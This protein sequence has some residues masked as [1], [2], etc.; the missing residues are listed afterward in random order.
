MRA[1][2]AFTLLLAAGCG[3][4]E[5]HPNLDR[6]T[7][8][9]QVGEWLKV[10]ARQTLDRQNWY[11]YGV[12]LAG[13]V[14][15]GGDVAVAAP[16]AANDMAGAS[17]PGG[18]GSAQDWST[19][20]VQEE[21]VDEAD[22]VKNDG[23]HIFVL[24]NDGLSILDAWPAEQLHEAAFFDVEGTPTNLYFDGA[25]TV[26]I[27]SQLGQ[28]SPNPESG[29]DPLE[30]TASAAGGWSYDPISKLSVLDVA[31]RTAPQLV[32]E[33]YI[34]G[35]ISASR[36]IGSSLHVITTNDLTDF[37]WSDADS[38]FGA[39]TRRRARVDQSEASDWIPTMQDNV[40]RDG[41]WESTTGPA[42]TCEATFRPNVR[43]E[44]AWSSI[45]TLDLADP[46]AAVTSTG[47]LAR[48]DVAYASTGALYL[49]MSEWEQG[50]FASQD[51][52]VQSRI[53]RFELSSTGAEYD[54]SGVVDGSLL[55]SYSLGEFGGHLRVAT[56]EWDDAGASNAVSVLRPQS[57]VLVEVGKVDG[58][59][60]GESIYAVRF[61][62]D[63]GY[64]VTFQQID[65]LFTLDLSDPADP[66]VV[67]ELEVTGFSTYL[68]P[69]DED[70]LLAVGE[71]ISADG[72]SWMGFQVSL[73]DVTD[74]T[75]P[76]LM[77][78]VIAGEGYGSSEAQ[79]DPHAF[80]WY[81]PR[82]TLG[83]PL[84][85]YDYDYGVQETS[86]ELYHVDTTTGIEHTG[87]VDHT[88]FVDEDTRSWGW[89]DQVRRSIFIEDYVFAVSNLGVQ[90]AMIDDP[91]TTLA[92]FPLGSPSCGWGGGMAEVF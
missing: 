71:E 89:C 72:W 12:P 28:V 57:G 52:S 5:A 65:P 58:I 23:D 30:T 11:G 8:C 3:A 60:R 27:F 76:E 92:S 83:L 75:E 50:P 53:H 84:V 35:R 15:R 63:R 6:F 46:T 10:S 85:D 87:S 16:E 69:I 39:D 18:G 29:A 81:A 43:T 42:A 91:S 34:D 25:D 88:A 55:S 51:G 41:S 80:T 14:T 77:D 79:W 36:R 66:R 38:G 37:L 73:F 54:A 49:A 13:G 64:V 47:V 31:D 9:A 61:V 17:A 44:M 82:S 33:T 26:V 59:A 21:G 45:H 74:F 56:S 24:D 2:T 32:R 78:R 4:N 90:V 67:G 1:L 68:H 19:T 20:T 40:L 7:D 70:H 62:G 86:L 48:A 22:F